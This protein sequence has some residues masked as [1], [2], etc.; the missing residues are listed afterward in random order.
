MNMP[1]VANESTHGSINSI[2]IEEI[3]AIAPAAL[4]GNAFN[5]A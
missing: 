4:L 2:S 1:A 5:I 3:I